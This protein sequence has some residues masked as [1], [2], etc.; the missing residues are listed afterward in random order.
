MSENKTGT[1]VSLGAKL[2][3]FKGMAIVLGILI[4]II[5]IP[6]CG[7]MFQTQT[8]TI[9]YSQEEMLI[10]KQHSDRR[11]V[12]FVE[13]L[14]FHFFIHISSGITEDT[15]RNIVGSFK[16][17]V[18]EE[19]EVN[20]SNGNIVYDDDGNAV[21][22]ERPIE[23]TYTLNQLLI[24]RQF[25][26]SDIEMANQFL[27]LW[28]LQLGYR[29]VG[30]L[31]PDYVVPQDAFIW[32]APTTKIITSR[33]GERWGRQHH[34]VD[35]SDSNPTGNPVVAAADGKIL[36]VNNNANNAC[37]LYIRIDHQNGHQT[38]YCHLESISVVLNQTVMKG[39]VIG[40]LGNTGTSTTGAHL[41][42]EMKIN[43]VL[44]DPLPYIIGSQP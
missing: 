33:Y 34:G 16:H 29:T 31:P 30:Q 23:K 36:Q 40:G 37:G 41:H 6:A 17:T 42:F 11:N 8:N 28:E 18:M 13:A 38:R 3:G 1:V 12:P 22:E 32:P 35:I 27:M 14:V 43:G 25:S 39:E 24:N 21:M 7:A 10:L 44:V 5:L 9:P 20:D 19:R 4:F 15:A 2:I 26:E